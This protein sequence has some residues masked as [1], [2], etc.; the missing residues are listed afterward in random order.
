MSEDPKVWK[1]S[2]EPSVNYHEDDFSKG[3]K[4]APP[5]A[6]KQVTFEKAGEE[7]QADESNIK[8]DANPT[9]KKKKV[10]NSK[11]PL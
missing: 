2:G 3:I 10:V 8:K 7:T 11:K 5:T 6:K 4:K 9:A 1:K